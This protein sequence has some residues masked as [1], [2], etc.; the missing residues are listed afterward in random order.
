MNKTGLVS[1][2]FRSLSPENIVDIAQK[3]QFNAIEWGGDVH[4]PHGDVARAKEVASM[5]RD[6][7]L[8]TAAYGS[9]YR[10]GASEENGLQFERVLATAIDLDAPVIRVWAGKWGSD[11][12]GEADKAH[13][14]ADALRIADMAAGGEIKIGLEFHG[15]TLN[16]TPAA[17]RDL[18]AVLDHPNIFSLWQPLPTL[19]L[20]EQD[21]SLS[22]VLP[23]LCH[24]HVYHMLPK[25]P[26][27]MLPLA[28]GVKTWRRW[29]SQIKEVKGTVT[30]LLEFVRGDSLEQF[31]ADAE[32]LRQI[33]ENNVPET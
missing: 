22:A 27:E 6:A 21:E 19:S 24:L 9:Y 25:A 2:T 31:S 5:T 16:D 10:A 13:V 30:G 3:E 1:V 20:E 14:L 26:V 4:V 17:A 18:F 12:I 29:V 7:G 33:F 15:N 28:D 8:Q 11:V 32:A 23:R